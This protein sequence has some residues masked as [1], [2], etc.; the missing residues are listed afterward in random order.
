[1][2]DSRK[3]IEEANK[4]TVLLC[5]HCFS[6]LPEVASSRQQSVP[7]LQNE[8]KIM[9]PF[10]SSSMPQFHFLF[11]LL[12]LEIVGSYFI[13]PCLEMRSNFHGNER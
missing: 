4:V 2:I 9:I 11:N 12:G 5:A 10:S 3:I 8:I 7:I 6:V 1:L 13:E